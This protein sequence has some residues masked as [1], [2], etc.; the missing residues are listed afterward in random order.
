MIWE[1]TD[2]YRVRVE[3]LNFVLER[4]HHTKPTD[5]HPEGREVWRERRA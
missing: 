2:T 5:E 1:I 3:P 4:R